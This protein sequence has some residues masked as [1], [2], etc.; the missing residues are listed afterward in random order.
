MHYF[1]C[2]ADTLT[3]IT[4][5]GENLGKNTCDLDL[6]RVEQFA[7]FYTQIFAIWK[8]RRKMDAKD[9]EAEFLR[10]YQRGIDLLE[11]EESRIVWC[12]SAEDMEEAHKQNKAAAFLS[13]EDLS[14]A[15][16]YAEQIRNLGFRFAMLTWN[17]EN[18]Y[19][20]GASADQHKGLTSEGKELVNCLLAQ[21]IVMDISHLSDQG[22][23]DLL[24][25]TDLP[26]I[27]SHSNV[28]SVCGHSRNLPDSLIRELVRRKG[29]I[30]INFFAPFVGENPQI[31]D[32]FRHMDIILSMGGED[33]LA[34]GGDF[35]GCDGMFPQNMTGVES[36]P[37]LKNEM[38]K[39][40][41]G[42]KLIEKIFYG[43]AEGFIRRNI[44]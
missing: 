31:S 14:I 27:A 11:K 35:D 12:R 38:K 41:F 21:N 39:T 29:I 9:P 19:A 18:V 15:G 10:L 42:D 20:C 7:D 25:M 13:I 23:D 34:L 40:G 37:L 22:A 26:V 2:H 36:V 4:N 5:T 28:R 24:N 3:E 16:K 30:G 33:I 17:Y 6:D 1:D 8:D 43:N 44:L 32:L